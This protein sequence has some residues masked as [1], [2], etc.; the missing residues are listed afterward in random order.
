MKPKV[1]KALKISAIVIASLFLLHVV[2]SVMVNRL[3]HHRIEQQL[4]EKVQVLNGKTIRYGSIRTGIISR[5]VT[6][7]DLYFNSTTGDSLIT[8]T[9]GFEVS[10]DKVQ[11]LKVDYWA[12]LWDQDIAIRS[13]TIN[14][15]QMRILLN[16]QSLQAQPNTVNT[17]E[18][19]IAYVARLNVDELRIV[20]A[21]IRWRMTDSHLMMDV[22]DIDLAVDNLN[23]D[24]TTQHASYNDS[25]YVLSIHGV[26]V[27]T[28]DSLNYM[29]VGSLEAKNA[30]AIYIKD[31]TQRCTVG[32]RDLADRSHLPETWAAVYVK[33]VQTTPINIIQQ[34]LEQNV[35]V[36]TLHVWVQSLRVFEDL[37]YPNKE[38]YPM[39]Q[40][41][42][43][44]LDVPF[45]VKYVR[46]SVD[47][48]YY[49]MANTDIHDG[50]LALVHIKANVKNFGN[51]N[52]D[53]F[54][55]KGSAE[56]IGGGKADIQ[57][58]MKM[59]RACSWQV[60]LNGRGMQG[61]AFDGFLRPLFGLTADLTIDEV[62]ADYKG[63]RNTA[64]GDFKLLYHGLEVHAYP[65]ES[66]YDIIN[67]NAK[68]I[69][70]FGNA[71]LPKSNPTLLPGSKG[72]LPSE[73][74]REYEVKAKRDPM[75]KVPV[76]MMMPVIDGLKKTMLPGLYVQ[77]KKDKKKK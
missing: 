9:L 34:V 54:R 11:V 45:H 20:D 28:P 23:F 36:D 76:Y 40:E 16:E 58:S 29:E 53:L 21:A 35:N 12:L 69:E 59:D 75:V 10:V 33:Q 55:V 41:V 25:T 8:D 7:S 68:A 56:F 65:G 47:T 66:A 6:I 63:D 77:K 44:S 49:T 43:M 19:M 26:R 39:P 67:K 22:D 37:R 2:A 38:P 72:N 48:M 51:R 18:Q 71:F 74:P 42:L 57:I 17:G 14:H 61:S 73:R 4:V 15:P 31:F 3:L 60:K 62:A 1:F 27:L 24:F 70:A 64:S 5:T 30:G 52:R 46:A 50:S 13:V 32:Y